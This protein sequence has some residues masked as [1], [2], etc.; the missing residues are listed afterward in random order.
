MIAGGGYSIYKGFETSK[1][2]E[3]NKEAIEELGE[4]FSTEIEPLV[5]DVDGKTTKLTGSAEQ[6]YTKWKKLLNKIY[7]KETGF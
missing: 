2:S 6:Q 3:I 5:I 7:H 1:E 4:S